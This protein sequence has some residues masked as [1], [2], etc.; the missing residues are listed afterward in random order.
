MPIF[1]Y[2]QVGKMEKVLFEM[3]SK[4]ITV[5]LALHFN[6]ETRDNIGTVQRR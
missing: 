6:C 5:I 3:D 4:M 1:F 2:E